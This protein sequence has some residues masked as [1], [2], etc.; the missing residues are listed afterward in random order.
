MLECGGMRTRGTIVTAEAM[1]LE[2]AMDP[3]M[4]VIEEKL[5]GNAT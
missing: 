5:T 3:V 1:A 4:R 2:T